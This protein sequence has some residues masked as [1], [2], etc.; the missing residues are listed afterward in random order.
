[1]A[2]EPE[3]GSCKN[4]VKVTPRDGTNHRYKKVALLVDGVQKALTPD[5]DWVTG[6]FNMLDHGSESDVAGTEFKLDW[7]KDGDNQFAQVKF[8]EIDYEIG[9]GELQFQGG[10]MNL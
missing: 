1:M 10:D 7:T 8:I 5:S 4:T 9:S 6:P 3:N 2:V